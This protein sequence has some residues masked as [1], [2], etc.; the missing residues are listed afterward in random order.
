LLISE[1]LKSLTRSKR[2]VIFNDLKTTKPVSRFFGI[3]RG[4]PIDRRY[5]EFFLQK[6]SHLIKGR[7]LEVGE[8][9][10]SKKFAGGE[11]TSFEVFHTVPENK[12]ATIIG[13][14]TD[15]ATLPENFADCF[16][17][18]QTFNFIFEVHKAIVGA[19]RLLK[20]DGTLL[21]TVAGIS[22]IS[23][24][25]M[26]R[27][28]DYWRFTTASINRL[29]VPV[30]GDSLQVETYG[31]VLAST[32]FLQ[33]VAV[34]DLPDETLLDEKDPDYQMLITIIARKAS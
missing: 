9:V 19:H 14:L 32:A 33:G 2:K 24:Y 26:E 28:G 16:I 11:V 17:C 3:E 6:N 22:Q 23:R 4:T 1:F 25:D 20:P 15:P 7:V 12:A 8:A 18:T 30:F 31:N 34:E 29:F 5:I 10:Y 21:A 27:W 13:D